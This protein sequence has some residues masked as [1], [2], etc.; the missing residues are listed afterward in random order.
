MSRVFEDRPAVRERTPLMVGLVGPSGSGKT[1]SALR[2]ATGFQRVTGG[3]VYVIDTE[4]R[5]ALH[6]ADAFKFRHLEFNAPFGSLDYLAAFEHCVAK[7]AKTIIVDS[8]SHEHEGPGGVLEQ[9][10]SELDRLAG[11][12]YA[13]RERV[14]MLAWAK[15]K[16]ARRRMIGTMLQMQTNFV[17]CFRAKEK[18][19][20]VKG[21]KQP[22][23]LGW[24]PI[25]GEELI[26]ESTLNCLLLP[27]S[28]GIPAWQTEFPG[29]RSI[30]KLPSQF[31]A[32][33]KDGPQ[34]SED[35]GAQ[36]ANWAAGT[37]PAAAAQT[38]SAPELAERFALC[39]NE[40]TFNALETM[41]A[42][43]WPTISRAD[44]IYVKAAS[45]KTRE[46][47]SWEKPADAPTDEEAA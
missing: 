20:M 14:N 13:K 6:Y 10:D 17:C 3:D 16:A 12:D 34:L 27:Q 47:L 25:A 43:A 29:E 45:D 44:K 35:L 24:M 23:E 5:R 2:L 22:V 37:A 32:L 28:N 1:Y 39:T 30:M 36:L 8:M 31:A 9:H 11:N 40:A 41:R 42:A 18:L 21:E 38:L 7:G 15:P 4:A 26:Y 46:R 33:F 19:K